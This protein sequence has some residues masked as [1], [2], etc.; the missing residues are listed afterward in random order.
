ME[1]HHIE[2]QEMHILR[3]ERG[4]ARG[5][6]VFLVFLMFLGFLV[7]QGFLAYPVVPGV[8]VL[9][10]FQD[11]MQSE[12][13]TKYSLVQCSLPLLMCSNMGSTVKKIDP[14]VK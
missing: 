9:V 2:S 12:C 5:F 1:T 3:E 14:T 4:S 10:V 7:F 11:S 13:N 8:L 6:L